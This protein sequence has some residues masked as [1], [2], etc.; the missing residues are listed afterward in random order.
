MLAGVARPSIAD[1]K[2]RAEISLDAVRRIRIDRALEA[3]PRI[4]EVS[5]DALLLTLRCRRVQLD[6]LRF[7]LRN[8]QR[9]GR[10]RGKVKTRVSLLARSGAPLCGFDDLAE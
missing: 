10:K 6:E 2:D 3:R 1:F 5:L 7:V 8:L 4:V 9:R